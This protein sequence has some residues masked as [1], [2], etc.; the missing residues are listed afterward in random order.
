MKVETMKMVVVDFLTMGNK[1]SFK[2]IAVFCE[3]TWL[4]AYKNWA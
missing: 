4:G 3:L 1:I 2:E